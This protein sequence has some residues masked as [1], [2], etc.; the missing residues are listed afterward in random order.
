[1]L[2]YLKDRGVKVKAGETV[3]EIIDPLDPFAKDCRLPIKAT[4]AGVLFSR[5][6]DGQLTF[7]GQVVFRMA[8]EKEL[9]HRVGRPG[10]DD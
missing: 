10:T 7:P 1:M 6:R 4:A 2:V 5:R 8:C 3:C 9:P